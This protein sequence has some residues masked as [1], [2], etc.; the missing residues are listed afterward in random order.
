[1]K[2]TI[3]G[4]LLALLIVL[5]FN[6]CSCGNSNKLYL[7]NWD[8]YMDEDLLAEFESLYNCEIVY[9]V[10]LSNET[11]YS[12][13]ASNAAP[14]DL[15]FPSDY[16]I[17][18]MKEENLLSPIDFTK[19]ENYRYSNFDSTLTDLIDRDCADIKDYFVPYF[20]GSLGI[21]YNTNKVSKELVEEN[22][23]RVLFDKELTSG[24][25][26]GMYASARDS[27]ASALLFKGFSLNTE[28]TAELD[29][30]KDVLL[31]MN[32][33]KWETDALKS[34]VADGKLDIALVYSGDYFDMV[35]SAYET[36]EDAQLSFD[37][38]T[39]H[40]KNNVF[41]DAIVIPTT[42]KN[43]E[44]AYKF[45]DFMINHD[46]ALRNAQY[47]GYCPTLTSVYNA[48]LEDE[49]YKNITDLDPY[50]PGDIIN[51]EIYQYLGADIY[52]YYDDIYRQVK[53]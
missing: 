27:I 51:G 37:C 40:D 24:L 38:Y 32:Y 14:Y 30:A 23:W 10:A 35:Y 31:N 9:D 13:I 4:T 20:W 46:N 49:D 48:M 2:K 17:S 50:Y 25:K 53:K 41:F 22:S 15:V 28:N 29:A 18:Q 6:L 45:I 19:L 42:S 21:M 44:L 5:C 8:E 7:L 39:P 47:V 1:M 34:D 26:V 11:M 33:T 36:S 3:Q 12:K 43:T 16:M 52:R